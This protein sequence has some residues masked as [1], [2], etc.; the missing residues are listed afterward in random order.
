MLGKKIN[1]FSVTVST[2]RLLTELGKG[3]GVFL[4]HNSEACRSTRAFLHPVH[5]L[6]YPRTQTFF[7]RGGVRWWPFHNTQSFG[8]SRT[9]KPT[10]RVFSAESRKEKEK[11]KYFKAAILDFQP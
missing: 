1:T 5:G 7:R 3:E 11:K 4:G 10:I 6:F 2:S 9:A 8:A